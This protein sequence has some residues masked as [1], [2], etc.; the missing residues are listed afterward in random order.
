[1]LISSIIFR[2]ETETQYAKS[3]FKLS[4]KLARACRESVG[5]LN[6]AWKAIA[7]E[8][9]ARAEMHKLLGQTLLDE[10]AKPLRTLTENQ[11]KTRKI[12]EA[13]VDKAARSLAE[14]RS[15]ESKS[16]KQS[17]TCARDNEKLQDAAV[18]DT[19]KSGKL[20]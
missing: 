5:G 17:H 7:I 11:H 19:A 13:S 8:L 18:L 15:A 4:A 10:T 20:T 9:E 1:M 16:K 2:A 14:W 6:D 3:L 12:C